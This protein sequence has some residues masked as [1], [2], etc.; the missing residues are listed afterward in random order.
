M[1][2]QLALLLAFFACSV[3]HA[4]VSEPVPVQEP[5]TI[6]EGIVWRISD[7]EDRHGRFLP[8]WKE[9]TITNIFGFESQPAAGHYVSVIPLDVNIP[10]LEL[11]IIKTE[12]K[13]NPC[14]DHLPS[15]WEVQLES[16]QLTDFFAIAPIPGRSATFPFD[17]CLLY[18]PVQSARQIKKELLTSDMLPTGVVIDAVRAAIPLPAMTSR[19]SLFSN[20]VVV[21]P[22][23]RWKHVR[24]GA[25]R[26]SRKRR[27]SGNSFV[28]RRHVRRG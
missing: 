22:R 19:T 24:V 17:V 25:G 5:E 9:I 12:P 8:P 16:I 23:G 28:L 4:D 7:H 14:D 21:T 27:A 18:P 10:P 13:K 20:T 3:G 15:W 26:R 11:R 2:I 6:A 1:R